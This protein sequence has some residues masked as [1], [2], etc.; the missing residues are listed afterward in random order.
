M[1]WLV[2][3]TV[4]TLAM[5]GCASEHAVV[6]DAAI[7]AAIDGPVDPCMA[8]RA[9]QLCVSAYDGLCNNATACV[10]R[11]VACPGN[12][13]SPACEAA[14]CAMPY[15]CQNRAPCGTEARSPTAFTCYG[16]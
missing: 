16:P 6:P 9:D 2:A 11:T 14:Y 15:Q 13:C 8:C 3:L 12:T 5:G 10:T 7:D 4:V 1:R